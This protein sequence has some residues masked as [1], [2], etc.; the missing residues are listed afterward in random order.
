MSYSEQDGQV[1]L[2]MSQE[3]YEKVMIRLGMAAAEAES[4]AEEFALV[5]RLN[6][7]NPNY[8]PHQ[9]GATHSDELSEEER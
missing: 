8:T 6:Q 5:N 4:L 2:T 7:G 1:T 9:V 3:D